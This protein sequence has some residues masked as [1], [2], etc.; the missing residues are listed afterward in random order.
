MI[1][2]GENLR[3]VRGGRVV[4][5]A[6]SFALDPGAVLVLTGPNGS[7]KSSLLRLMAGLGRPDGGRIAWDGANIRDD[8][9]AHAA[10]LSYVGH[11]DAVKPALTVRENVAQWGGSENDID[12]AIDRFGLNPALPA[13]FLSAGQKRRCALTRL[14][15][16]PAPLWLLDEP[17]V[18]LD[19]GSVAN[20]LALIA[21]HRD[22]G[23]MCAISTNVELVLPGAA[24]LDLP[25]F[26]AE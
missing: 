2:T 18:A 25:G 21:A 6:L 20:L 16:R 4:F 8:P 15:A 14:L 10:R 11:L 17:T 19:R 23:G 5:D 24:S 9:E 3:C 22:E 12:S 1:F 13:R 26:A 7:G